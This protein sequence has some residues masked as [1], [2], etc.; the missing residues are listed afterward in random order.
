[1][2]PLALGLALAVGAPALKDKPP[3]LDLAGEWVVAAY[4]LG[5]K[6]VPPGVH[7]RF[8]A[9]GA[10]TFSGGPP[11][12]TTVGE[13]TL[14]AARSPAEVDILFPGTGAG[15]MIGIVKRD[16]DD[17]VL[18]FGPPGARP[19]RFESPAGSGVGLL[20]LKRATTKD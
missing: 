8:A 16:G 2:P 13:Y 11:A 14:N 19:T 3:A 15:A 12:A 1:V 10:A 7:I 6:E 9:D 18:C 4:V 20:T 5:G 17:L